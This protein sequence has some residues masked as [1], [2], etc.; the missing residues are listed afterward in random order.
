MSPRESK[1]AVKLRTKKIISSLEKMYPDAH[2]SLDHKNP[3]QL[4]IATMLS[5]QC[6]DA[7]VNLTTPALFAKYKTAKDFSQAHIEDLERLVRSTGFYRNKAKN[8]KACAQSLMDLHNGDVPKTMEELSSLAGV[9][10]KTAN[11]VLGN[12]YGIPG[13][14]VDTHVTRLSNRLGIAVGVDAVKLETQLMEVVSKKNWT[15]FS[16]LL[17]SHGREICVARTPRCKICK[18]F[19]LCSKKGVTKMAD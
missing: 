1:E 12:A 18:I 9:G 17:I 19:R 5:A 15:D 2:C 6:T 4:L 3:L 13:M 14:V 10:R 16:H 8:I 11:V 7:R